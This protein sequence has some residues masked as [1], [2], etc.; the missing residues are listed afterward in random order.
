MLSTPALLKGRLAK[1]L[2]LLALL[3][4]LLPELLRWG[5]IK[6]LSSAGLGAASIDDVDLNLFTGTL[7]VRGFTL[8]RD[9]QHKLSFERMAIDMSWLKALTGVIYSEQFSLEGT[10]L[11]VLQAADGH[12]EV[13][14]P[15]TGEESDSAEKDDAQAPE[16]FTLP[17][18]A[19]ERI[20]LVDVEIT[21]DSQLVSGVLNVDQLH[22]QRISTWL[23]EAAT[24]TMQAAWNE[25]PFTIEV[26]ASPWID[27]PSLQMELAF[28]QVPLEALVPAFDEPLRAAVTMAMT[29]DATRTPQGEI[30]AELAGQ[31]SIDQ[32]SA[33]VNQLA[34]SGEQLTWQGD[35]KFHL[36]QQQLQYQLDGDVEIK[37][38]QLADQQQQLVV[39]ALQRLRAGQLALDQ[40]LNL[41]LAELQLDGLDMLKQSADER[42]S[43]YTGGLTVQGVDLQQ[44]S[45]LLIE[46][47]A[48]SDGQYR[49]T[50]EQD[51][52]L[53][54]QKALSAVLAKQPAAD[55]SQPSAE[56]AAEQPS[57]FSLTLNEFSVAK[58][59]QLSFRD[60]RFTV[61]V[62]QQLSI[63]TLSLTGLD[64]Q[65]PDKA[66]SLA[67]DGNLGEFSALTVNGTLTPFAD[68]LGL[69]LKGELDGMQLPDIS[70]YAEAYMGYHLTRGQYDHRFE[71]A[72]A[73][74]ALQ[75]ENELVLRKLRLKSVDPDKVQPMARELDV[76]LGVALDMLRDG[77]DNIRLEVPIEG[78]MD[79]PDIDISSIINSALAKALKS[80]ASSYLKLALQPYGAVFMAA[81]FVGKQLS[82]IT[83][84]PLVFDSGQSTL[85]S[86]HLA[87]TEKI[88]QV[89]QE[90]PKLEVT[91]CATAGAQDKLALQALKPEQ[92]V[93]EADLV[94]LA[95]QRG[96]NVKRQLLSHG[97]AGRRLFV[98]QPG[99][100]PDAASEVTVKM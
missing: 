15:L 84:D 83:L 16:G 96:N 37:G 75:L 21:V 34:L 57:P 49:V 66:A 85:A 91:L 24:L 38:L 2:L 65:Q 87:Y 7:A 53:Q 92:P 58:G 72:I 10:R 60:E 14:I 94:A 35:A 17:R 73:D 95:D 71:L 76:P 30:S 5:A 44:A 81:E 22:L 93:A 18:L 56:P 62:Q 39:L 45:Q 6:G 1:A 69:Q 77:D 3:L 88:A 64:Q 100:Q 28:E 42:G 97:V 68:K 51:G 98:C 23:S 70:P 33:S 29:L 80:G 90:R 40:Q 74:D 8:Q 46:R 52:Q 12:W 99:F 20:E 59:S 9:A 41:S 13:V 11:R 61:P 4:L 54:L 55:A 27:E 63:N 47:L 82:A 43:L 79:K 31:L 89:L 25:A 26:T 86:D 36:A 48:I 19:A 78:R 32:L 67:L 50:L